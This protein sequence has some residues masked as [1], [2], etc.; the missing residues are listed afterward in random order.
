[1]GGVEQEKWIKELYPKDR[2]MMAMS[3]KNLLPK[4][5]RVPYN[6]IISQGWAV[7]F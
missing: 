6:D 5:L 1:M 7:P 2:Y 3:H 4:N